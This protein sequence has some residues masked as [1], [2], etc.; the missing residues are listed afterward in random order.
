ME[1]CLR[2]QSKEQLCPS[3]TPLSKK[4]LLSINKK[5]MQLRKA[6]K[7]YQFNFF[8]NDQLTIY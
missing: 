7:R 4:T 3:L 1:L 2:R 5:K 8:V 6:N